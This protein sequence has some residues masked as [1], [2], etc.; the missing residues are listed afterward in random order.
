MHLK[1]GDRIGNWVVDKRLGTG[2][3]GSVYRCRSEFSER[4]IRAIKVLAPGQDRRQEKRFIREMEALTLMNHDAI[5]RALDIGRDDHLKSLYIIMELVEGP[6][7]YKTW[8]S[9]KLPESRI[10][11]IVRQIAAGL[12]HAHERGFFHRDIKPENIIINARRGPVLVDFGVARHAGQQ[13]VTPGNSF[14]GT[15]PYIPP[16]VFH[17]FIGKAV[18]NSQ[19]VSRDTRARRWDVYSLGQILFELLVG[20]PTF[21]ENKSFGEIIRAKVTIEALDP[22][23]EFSDSMRDLVVRSTAPDPLDRVQ[24][25]GT[26]IAMLDAA[27]AQEERSPAASL[28][29]RGDDGPSAPFPLSVQ[30]T[31]PLLPL[32]GAADPTMDVLS[33]SSVPATTHPDD[34]PDR[35]AP[36]PPIRAPVPHRLEARTVLRQGP[37]SPGRSGHRASEKTWIRPRA[38]S[39]EE[40]TV[41]YDESEEPAWQWRL[42]LLGVGA[43]I[44]VVF[45]V[46]VLVLGWWMLM[47]VM[48]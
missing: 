19:M 13:T 3:M 48:G 1:S 20:R 5:V 40:S 26:F 24:D 44:P 12:H 11:P 29:D 27:H 41:L 4:L 7:L 17:R 16:E 9:G 21:A 8:R 18:E 38:A 33:V 37:S 32:K 36:E 10:V 30:P 23:D 6:T 47:G 2:G 35:E 15:P 25:M 46:I 43:T 45:G 42:I 28:L 22:G 14:G 31:P 34:D 39:V